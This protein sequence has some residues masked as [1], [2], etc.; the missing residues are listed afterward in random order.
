MGSNKLALLLGAALSCMVVSGCVSI[1]A[2]EELDEKNSIIKNL[3]GQID[4]MNAEVS[5]LSLENEDLRD[6]KSQ[7]EGRLS[8]LESQKGGGDTVKAQ[9]Q[10]PEEKI[11]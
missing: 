9:T 7:L 6:S 4:T 10:A 1:P 11:K 3:S 8:R 5:R 2:A